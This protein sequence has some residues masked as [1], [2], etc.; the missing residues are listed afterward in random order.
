MYF[1]D[2]SNIK[3]ISKSIER[4]GIS[5]IKKFVDK[6]SIFETSKKVE[7]ILNKPHLLKIPYNIKILKK[8]KH[9]RQPLRNLKLKLSPKILNKGYKY[10]SQ[11]TNSI[12][13]KNPL[14]NLP[15]INETIFD[16]RIIN[17]AK[18]F[19]KSNPVIGY[20]AV[21][22]QFKNKL[23]END[24]NLFHVDDALTVTPKKSR[25]LKLL[26]PFHLRNK[27][28]IEYRHLNMKKSKINGADF[29]KLQ[30]SNESEIPKKFKKF[31]VKPKVLSRDMFLVD[32]DNFF[33][34]VDKPRKLRIMLYLV[35]VKK[36][37]YM[38]FK[39]RK[40][41]IKK[42]FFENLSTSQKSFG[43]YLNLV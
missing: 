37:N 10:Y 42:I 39:T 33:H 32:P 21:G 25:L 6:K 4:N 15:N 8:D 30:Y 17:I 22:C 38:L 5:I 28:K 43:R 16:E 1:K 14:I 9:L 20:V 40:I 7:G 31:I 41:K 3:K 13:I 2:L 26:I 19:L 34:R 29:K 11:F 27:E 36:E 12:Q 23:V 18:Y 35:F 24:L